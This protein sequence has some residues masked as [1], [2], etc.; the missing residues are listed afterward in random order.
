MSRTCSEGGMSLFG[1]GKEGSEV[2]EE[3]GER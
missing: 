3:F 1:S 2:V